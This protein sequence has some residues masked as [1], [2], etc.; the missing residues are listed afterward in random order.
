ML[1][2]TI[3]IEFENSGRIQT[4]YLRTL[5]VVQMLHLPLNG[6]RAECGHDPSWCG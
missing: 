2:Q 6:L 1:K 5:V 4:K 3:Y